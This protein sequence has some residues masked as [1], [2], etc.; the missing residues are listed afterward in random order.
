[1]FYVAV[2]LFGVCCI[3]AGW[4][5]F[6]ISS[7]GE[8][9]QA[10]NDAQGRISRLEEQLGR[11]RADIRILRDENQRVRGYADEVEGDRIKLAEINRELEIILGQLRADNRRLGRTIAES[12]ARFDI[13]AGGLEDLERLL[14]EIE[15]AAD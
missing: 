1:M 5:Y 3:L 7:D 6:N 4:I 15:G 11:S 10:Y 9:E 14:Q 8:F 13:I 2:F 12:R